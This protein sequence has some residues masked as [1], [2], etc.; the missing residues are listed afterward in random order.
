MIRDGYRARRSGAGTGELTT[1]VAFLIYNRPALTARVFDAIRRVK[2]KKLLVVADGPRCDNLDDVEKC[3][4][5]RSIIDTVD[6]DCEVLT[7]YS[8]VNMGCKRRI[9]TGLDWVFK[10]VPEAIVLED[11]CLPSLGFFFF[12]QDLLDRHRHDSRIM[13]ICGF[14]RLGRWERGP[15]DYYFSRLGP[16]WGWA[17][18]DRAWAYYDVEI[19]LWPQI[20]G[21]GSLRS[22]C[23]SRDEYLWRTSLYDRLYRNKIDTWD[24]QW[25]FAKLINSGLS[26][27]PRQN[28]VENIG[29]GPEAT[30]TKCRTTPPPKRDISLPL[31]HPSFVLRDIEADKRHCGMIVPRFT[32]FKSLFSAK[33]T[34]ASLIRRCRNLFGRE[35]SKGAPSIHAKAC[36]TRFLDPRKDL[37]QTTKCQ[38]RSHW[39]FPGPGSAGNLPLHLSTVFILGWQLA[40]L[41]YLST[42]AKP[43]TWSRK[44]TRPLVR[45]SKMIAPLDYVRYREFEFAFSAIERHHPSPRNVLD[46]SSPRLLPL[47]LAYS[48]R[49]SSLTVMN[50]LEEETTDVVTA[51]EMLGLANLVGEIQDARRL[52][53]ADGSFDLVTSLSVIEHIAPEE[54]GEAEA[55]REI[56]RV[57][58]NGGIAI[59]TVP[60]SWSYFAEYRGV[61]VY[62]RT[63]E[64]DRPIFF[65]RFYDYERLM[66]DV[67]EESRLSLVELAF[68]QERFFL[69]SPHRR[70]AAYIN[71]S[72][73]Q[74]ILMGPYYLA[75]SKL[76]LSAPRDLAECTKPYI[77]CLVLQKR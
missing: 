63:A 16:V 53:Y 62:E 13:Q 65:Q 66:R 36:D 43:I 39:L 71:A 37:P 45:M 42:Q 67:V 8:P 75:L 40:R 14:N 38:G 11:D 21:L 9:S 22:A 46:V 48:K 54:Q 59:L 33:D 51:S 2:P 34:V 31:N 76:F 12:C 64:G 28:L 10:E 30:H 5:T 56:G 69:R 72:R 18:W 77:A 52:P 50:I 6:W 19:K 35:A 55:V 61:R 58:A 57:L 3:S 70:L 4:A 29:F 26:I 17:S 23:D 74:R 60:F 73:V 27:V 41:P 47:T 1:P 32:R 20:K 68:I 15:G 7:D 24:Y 49:D 25:G 44:I